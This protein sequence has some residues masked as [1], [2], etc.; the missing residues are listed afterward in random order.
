VVAGNGSNDVLSHSF[1]VTKRSDNKAE[2]RN[3]FVATLNVTKYCNYLLT[4]L[5]RRLM[6]K[7]LFLNI[8]ALLHISYSKRGAANKK[9]YFT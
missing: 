4:K 9:E 8:L 5:T 1:F 7:K 3:N 6:L 2:D